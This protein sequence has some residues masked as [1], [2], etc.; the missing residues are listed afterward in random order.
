MPLYIAFI[1][2]TK[3][4][5]LVS[6]RGLFQILKKIGYPPQLLSMTASFHGDMQGTVSYDGASSEPFKILTGVKQGCV[7]APTLFDIFFSVLLNFAFH[8]SDEGVHLVHTRNEGK[9]FNLTRLKS[10]AKVR[11][12]LIKEMLFADDAALTS[13][14]EEGLQQLISKFANA[15]NEFGLTISIKKTSVM[16]QDFPAVP[17]MSINGEVLEVTDRYTYLGFTITNNLSLDTE[18]NKRIAKAAAVL[19]NL[20]KRVWET[21]QLTWNT[22]LKVYQ[23]CVLGNLLYGSEFWTTYARQ[24][25]RLESFHLRCLRRIMGIRWQDRVTNTA[26]LEKAGSLSM[27][28]MLCQNRLRWL[29]HMHRKEDARI[30]KDILYGQLASECFPVGHPA[31]LT[32]GH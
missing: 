19:S 24:E 10:K 21:H 2:L 8:H 25:K 28:L 6:S 31:L 27:H 4:F 22:N 7:L 15:C 30:P 18:I 12:F 32:N 26:V 14:T 23:A 3:A 20:S 1:D 16:G 9:L 29:G 11:T 17:S 5:D 13:H